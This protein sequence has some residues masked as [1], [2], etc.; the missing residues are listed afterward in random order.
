MSSD[1]IERQGS[2]AQQQT[3]RSAIG[4][5]AADSGRGDLRDGVGRTDDLHL[6]LLGILD[7]RR[8]QRLR[9]YVEG[10]DGLEI[11]SGGFE[12]QAERAAQQCHEE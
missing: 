6:G 3:Q 10:S 1:R 12:R 8:F 9:R 11:C 2:T 4:E 5:I 7:Q